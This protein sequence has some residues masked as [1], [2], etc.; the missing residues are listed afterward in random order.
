MKEYSA[1]ETIVTKQ[2][3]NSLIANYGIN[4]LNSIFLNN[5]I[6]TQDK[7]YLVQD[8]E[9]IFNTNLNESDEIKLNYNI[10]TNAPVIGYGSKNSGVINKFNSN[11]KLAENNK[12]FINIS[13]DKDN[14]SWTFNSK[15]NPMFSDYKK[16]LGDI[17]E[18]IE[19][20]T[21]EY[22]NDKIY[23]NSLAVIDLIDTL[24]NQDDSITNV[25][26]EKDDD[27]MYTTKYKAVN[28]WVRYKTDIDLTLARYFG[29]SYRYGSVTK[30]I[31]DIKIEKN[32]KLPYIDNLLDALKGKFQAA[33]DIINGTNKVKSAVKGATN[34]SYESWDRDTTW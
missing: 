14:Y 16:I 23:E 13:I 32:T 7:D 15:R 34:Y 5:N 11:V 6:L 10:K 4:N 26:Y 12:Y 19:G 2:D 22:I 28:N 8:D 31:G 30:E 17:G 20:F 18:F 27:G 1:S 3:Q 21:E 33:D 24:A 29:I 25:T 9:V